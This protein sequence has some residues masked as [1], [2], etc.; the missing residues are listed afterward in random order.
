[1]WYKR[2]D[3][4]LSSIGFHKLSTDHCIYVKGEKGNM[5]FILVYVDD[6]VLGMHNLAEINSNKALL[7]Q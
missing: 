2:L 4:F 7:S 6:L 5:E 1:M 3:K